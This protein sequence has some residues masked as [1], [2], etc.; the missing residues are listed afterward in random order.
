M[1]IKSGSVRGSGCN[2]PG[3]LGDGGPSFIV[4]KSETVGGER[5]FVPDFCMNQIVV[6]PPPE[7]RAMK[8]LDL[9]GIR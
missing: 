5:S 6:M 2:S 8:I 4:W 3:L 9:C 7:Y 1:S